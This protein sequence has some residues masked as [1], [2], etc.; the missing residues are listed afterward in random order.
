MQHVRFLG[1]WGV[2]DS[3]FAVRAAVCWMWFSGI[4]SGRVEITGMCSVVGRMDDHN[5]AEKFDYDD[6][7]SMMQQ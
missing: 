2:V 5:S 7:L 4:L 6:T 3:N 1:T